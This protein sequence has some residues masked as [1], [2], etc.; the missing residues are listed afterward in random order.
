MGTRRD[1]FWRASTAFVSGLLIGVTM[2][3]AA[4]H[5][6]HRMRPQAGV[7]ST[8]LPMPGAFPTAHEAF[9]RLNRIE[10]PG[11]VFLGDSITDFWRYCPTIWSNHFAAFHAANFG[12]IA[13]RIEN[14]LWR[15]DNGEL[16]HIHPKVIVLLAGTNNLA[17]CGDQQIIAGLRGLL[18]VVHQ[19]QP[20]SHIVLLGIFPRHDVPL[21]RIRGINEK[22]AATGGVTFLDVGPIFLRPDGTVSPALMPD[23]LH[24]SPVGFERWGA[25][26]EPSL[27]LLSGEPP[28]H[29]AAAS[30]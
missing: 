27:A 3:V 20:T 17:T 28:I 15:V 11:V 25:A 13:D 23:G 1:S 18:R 29:L 26:I 9:L 22:L 24:P 8:L 16:D 5:I 19:K 12:V 21:A 6:R 7:V 2:V 4:V 14:V 30:Q 10:Q